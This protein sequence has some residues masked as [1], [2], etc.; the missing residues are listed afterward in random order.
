MSLILAQNIRSCGTKSC[1]KLTIYNYTYLIRYLHRHSI[2]QYSV[3]CFSGG[4]FLAHRRSQSVYSKYLHK[5]FQAVSANTLINSMSTIATSKDEKTLREK[6]S[7]KECK[8][9]TPY[10]HIAGL[11]WGKPDAPNKILALHGW[12]DNAGSFER[13]VP[14][15]L[16]HEDNANKYHIIA[17][18]MPGVGLSSHMPPSAIYS[19]FGVVIEMRRIVSMMKWN[20]I[21]LLS[22]SL[23]SHLSYMYS[24]LYP[25]QVESMIS[26]DL[27]HPITRVVHNWHVTLA[28]SIDDHLK[29]EYQHEEDPTT[30]M[31]VPVYSEEDAIKRLMDGHANSLNRESAIVMM[32]R[33]A[34]KEQWGYTFCRDVRWRYLSPEI[35]PND[36]LMLDYLEEAFRPNLLIIRASRSIYHRP[37][38]LRLRYYEL[39]RRKCPIFR[40]VILDGT[41]HLHMNSPEPVALEINKFLADVESNEKVGVKVVN[42]SNL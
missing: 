6:F 26:I 24:C 12:L 23:G 5:E 27:A 20:K 16:D 1:S 13:L 17:M 4:R 30:S 9:K 31:L 42:K 22:H 10:G 33:G 15:I 11:E 40:D 25:N 14:F 36:V 19:V 39:Y 32:K 7:P 3:Q 29:S 37:E 34:R 18:D 28:N 8:F 38:N 41:H 35:R 2:A 21:S